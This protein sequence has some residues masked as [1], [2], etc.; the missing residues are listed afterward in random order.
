[1][2]GHV[3][4][5]I[6]TPHLDKLAAGGIR[7]DRAYC[8]QP[9]CGPAR[10]SMF[11]GLFPAASGSWGNSIPLSDNVRTIGKRLSD[12]GITAGYIGKCI[13]TV[14]IILV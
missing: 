8:T 9:V 2:V 7:F 14:V 13:L 10:A 5:D 1:M 4:P 11:T 12:N 6:H 3:N